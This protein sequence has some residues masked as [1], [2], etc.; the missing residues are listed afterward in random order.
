MWISIKSSASQLRGASRDSGL[1][2]DRWLLIG[3]RPRRGGSIRKLP[4]RE[5]VQATT[6]AANQPGCTVACKAAVRWP[7]LARDRRVS[8]TGTCTSNR[9]AF[10]RDTPSLPS[11]CMRPSDSLQAQS[12]PE[13][14]FSAK[15]NPL[16]PWH[17][18][19]MTKEAMGCACMPRLT[20]SCFRPALACWFVARKRSAAFESLNN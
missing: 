1:C 19:L 18:P 4:H 2:L 5:K 7:R 20:R 10:A 14:A 3:E 8:P 9:N 11:P 12:D 16:H 6:Q 17:G 13:Q 15:H